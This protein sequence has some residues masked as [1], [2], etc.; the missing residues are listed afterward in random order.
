VARVLDGVPA[1]GHVLLDARATYYIDPDVLDL[2]RDFAAVTGPAWGV[3]VSLLGFRVKYQRADDIQYVD[4]STRAV[5]D[6]LTPE[7]VLRIL[8]DGN[9]RFR[10]GRRLTRDHG[11][12]EAGPAAG[13]HPLAVVVG[14]IDSRAPAELVFDL[15]VGDVL[16]ARAAGNVAAPAV[17]GSVEYGCAVAGAK[18]MLVMGHTRCGAV[19]AAVERAGMPQATAGQPP[20]DI[21]RE[22]QTS[23]GQ[24]TLPPD[25]ESFVRAVAVRNVCRTDGRL[26][27]ESPAPDRLVR[28]G[29]VRVVGAMY[30]LDSRTV[31]FLADDPPGLLG[32]A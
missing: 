19:S 24:P 12:G 30:D 13:Q 20:E 9:E 14:C 28:A 17:V 23:I 15:G 29:Q 10:T 25:R 3:E 26:R 4:S 27:R 6:R 7:Q 5:Q 22:I 16:S 11:W 2:L 1:G 32:P 31:E 8:A 21:I 18:L